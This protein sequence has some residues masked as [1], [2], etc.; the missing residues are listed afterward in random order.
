MN[1]ADLDAGYRAMAADAEREDEAQAWCK[2]MSPAL[3]FFCEQ[4]LLQFAV[5]RNSA[6]RRSAVDGPGRHCIVQLF[7]H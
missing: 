4:P 7:R 2:S 3:A 6:H 5:G 1:P